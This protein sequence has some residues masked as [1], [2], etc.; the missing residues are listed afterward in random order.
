MV[1]AQLIDKRG[2]DV[3]TTEVDLRPFPKYLVE[4]LGRLEGRDIAEIEIFF[5]TCGKGSKW[6]LLAGDYIEYDG[7]GKAVI[8]ERTRA[9]LDAAK[10]ARR[11]Q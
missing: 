9:L 3:S 7:E 2:V 10:R 8:T 6:L 11:N 5:E 4:A 1:V